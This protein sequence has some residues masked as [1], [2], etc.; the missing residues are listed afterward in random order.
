MITQID[1]IPYLPSFQRGSAI[2]T[3]TVTRD[4]N[5]FRGV[6]SA[7]WSSSG[8]I[9]LLTDSQTVI[10]SN[11]GWH[12]P[13]FTPVELPP[14][15][16][17]LTP[18]RVVELSIRMLPIYDSPPDG[19]LATNIRLY[20]GGGSGEFTLSA[21]LPGGFSEGVD[22]SGVWTPPQT[23]TDVA[24]NPP[25]GAEGLIGVR[26]MFESPSNVYDVRF[27]VLSFILEGE[28]TFTPGVSLFWTN[29]TLT[30]EVPL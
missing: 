18:T 25:E 9:I 21:D 10:N 8:G 24:F 13:E 4:G 14:E 16:S 22:S 15:L 17:A 20:Y 27:E 7:T 6:N 2:P 3:V 28:S 11:Y 26:F 12:T 5:V 29:K 19:F 30:R 23:V 1:M